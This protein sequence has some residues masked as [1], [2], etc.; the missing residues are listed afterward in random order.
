M[1]KD[2]SDTALIIKNCGI[3]AE[4]IN[5]L[6]IKY[7]IGIASQ[8]AIKILFLIQYAHFYGLF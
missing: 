7:S 3:P 5:I 2:L 8:F 1:I 4:Y 6:C